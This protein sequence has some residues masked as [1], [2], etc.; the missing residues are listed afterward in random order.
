[1]TTYARELR[2]FSA[3]MSVVGGIIGAGIFVSPAVVAQRVGSGGLTLAVWVLGGLVA[4]AGGFSFAAVGA[5]PPG[6]R[7]GSG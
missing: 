1:M 7:G 5:R 4:L 2:L 6:A 3:S